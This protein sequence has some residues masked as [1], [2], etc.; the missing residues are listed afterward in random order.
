MGEYSTDQRLTEATDRAVAAFR[1]WLAQV[2]LLAKTETHTR[3]VDLFGA[4]IEVLLGS[5]QSI[6]AVWVT[7]LLERQAELERRIA[8]LE[9]ATLKERE[10]GGVEARRQTRVR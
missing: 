4:F 5:V 2:N 6:I 8:A 10:H 7:P 3:L 1:A 9:Q